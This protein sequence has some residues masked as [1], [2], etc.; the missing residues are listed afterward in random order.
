MRSPGWGTRILRS[1]A[2]PRARIGNFGAMPPTLCSALS[3][4]RRPPILYATPGRDGYRRSEAEHGRVDA[5]L[6]GRP[7][8]VVPMGERTRLFGL[9][10]AQCRA[11]LVEREPVKIVAVVDDHQRI[12]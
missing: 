4:L 10:D 11:R 1:A 6:A 7:D 8:L 12:G 9:L 3:A 2:A 5:R